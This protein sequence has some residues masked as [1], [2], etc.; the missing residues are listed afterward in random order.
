MKL[1]KLEENQEAYVIKE[2]H[3]VKARKDPEDLFA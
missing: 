1:E 2:L 3:N